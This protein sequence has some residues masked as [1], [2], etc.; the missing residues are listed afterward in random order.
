MIGITSEGAAED[1]MNGISFD[2][3][4]PSLRSEVQVGDGPYDLTVAWSY[5]NEGGDGNLSCRH[6]KAELVS[7]DYF[8]MKVLAGAVTDAEGLV[9]FKGLST[10]L[11]AVVIYA[12]DR[13]TV[14]VISDSIEGHDT[15]SWST[16]TYVISGSR[17]LTQ[18]IGGTER[19]AWNAYDVIRT[20]ASWLDAQVG[21]TRDKVSVVWPTEAWPHS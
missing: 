10:G 20:A 15:Y 19:G 18:V 5:L 9:V 8:G 17:N 3:A 6:A 13:S 16:E 2:A 1:D 12:E 4:S 7:E 14:K 21:W 11:Y